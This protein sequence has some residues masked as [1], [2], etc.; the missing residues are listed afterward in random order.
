MEWWVNGDY[1]SHQR[2]QEL[3]NSKVQFH[4]GLRVNGVLSASITFPIT[5]KFNS[6]R[7]RCIALNIST[8]LE[9]SNAVLTIAGIYKNIRVIITLVMVLQLQFR[10][11]IYYIQPEFLKTSIEKEIIILLVEYIGNH[12]NCKQL[13]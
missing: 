11:P 12:K 13:R 1:S 2:N 7:L 10:L 4:K 5:E 9:S 8:T 3:I 6:T